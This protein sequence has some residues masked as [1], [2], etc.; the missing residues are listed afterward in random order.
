M[1]PLSM[2]DQTKWMV[3]K[4]MTIRTKQDILARNN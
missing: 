1:F 3:A 4:G 2:F